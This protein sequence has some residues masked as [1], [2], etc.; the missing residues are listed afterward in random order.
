MGI[1]EGLIN[2]ADG[3]WNV[4]KGV[5]KIIWGVFKLALLAAIYPIVGL[6]MIAEGIF[7]YAKRKY[8]EIKKKRPKVKLS[9]SGSMT[10]PKA[11]GNAIKNAKKEIGES[12]D[13][14]EFEKEDAMKDLD[15]M[16]NKLASGEIDGLQYIDGKNED[17]ED[18]ILDAELFKASSI[19]SN[20]KDKHIYRPFNN[21]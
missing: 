21:A 3:A 20:S 10:G 4:A 17:G 19:D 11:L 6:Y 9:G 18:D 13:L 12:I 7:N 5:G 8:R 2:V 15:E 14:D 16:Q 1:V